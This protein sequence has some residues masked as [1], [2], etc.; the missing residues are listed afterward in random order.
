MDLNCNIFFH[1]PIRR[2]RL[3]IPIFYSHS[4]L[5]FLSDLSVSILDR[6]SIT[7]TILSI[8]IFGKATGA[9]TT[10]LTEQLGLSKRTINRIYE[11]ALERGFDPASLP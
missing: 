7:L 9:S 10:I 11:R 4:I 5:E 6:V 3:D 2:Y 8:S 1:L